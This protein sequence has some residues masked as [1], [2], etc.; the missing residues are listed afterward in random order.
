MR[1][2]VTVF[3]PVNEPSVVGSLDD[4]IAAVTA[5]RAELEAA[6]PKGG[7]TLA[8]AEKKLARAAARLAEA[9]RQA[10]APCPAGKEGKG[11]PRTAAS[12]LPERRMRQPRTFPSVTPAGGRR[13]GS[14]SRGRARSLRP[15]SARRS[16][17]SQ[18]AWCGSGTPRRW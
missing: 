8:A 13:R 12:L 1:D 15:S 14:S 16:M 11:G 2:V 5:A 10:V 17:A 4:E 7:K 3:V 6:R 9:A 18:P